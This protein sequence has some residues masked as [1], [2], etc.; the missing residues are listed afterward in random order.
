MTS[1]RVKF[2]EDQTSLLDDHTD[3]LWRDQHEIV[4]LCF[5]YEELLSDSDH[6]YGRIC[7]LDNDWRLSVLKDVIPYDV[8]FEKSIE[9]LFAK[10]VT[11]SDKI[12]KLHDDRLGQDYAA[13]GFD[14]G[15]V[16]KLRKSVEE[17]RASMQP[18]KEFFCRDQTF[19][20]ADEAIE[21]LESG[22]VED[23]DNVA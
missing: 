5:D 8:V 23:M 11:V 4:M 19:E 22:D 13:H 3:E 12:V 7:D 2:V 16:E 1:F 15:P 17:V 6:I 10:W 21:L 14:V 18:D 9:G 20:M